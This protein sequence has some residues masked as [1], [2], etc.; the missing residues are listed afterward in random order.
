MRSCVNTVVFALACFLADLLLPFLA[1][2]ARSLGMV[3]V[4]ILFI[5][6]LITWVAIGRRINSTT[7][8]ANAQANLDNQTNVSGIVTVALTLILLVAVFL[9]PVGP[10][11]NEA[12]ASTKSKRSPSTAAATSSQQNTPSFAISRVPNN[13]NLKFIVTALKTGDIEWDYRPD[14]SRIVSQSDRERKWVGSQHLSKGQNS[15]VIRLDGDHFELRLLGSPLGK[16]DIEKLLS[17]DTNSL[18]AHI[19]HTSANVPTITLRVDSLNPFVLAYYY[20]EQR[21]AKYDVFSMWDGAYS[22]KLT[23]PK[24]QL[25]RSKVIVVAESDDSRIYRF[26]DNTL[27][28]EIIDDHSS[29]KSK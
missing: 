24:A 18:L 27:E 26:P 10:P 4:C 16:A 28:E 22:F 15:T 20:D 5:R 13:D 12:P 3:V 21:T 6:T 9:L 19:V 7:I 11:R 14:S 17:R 29:T 23:I 1:T 8:S 25:E 2:P